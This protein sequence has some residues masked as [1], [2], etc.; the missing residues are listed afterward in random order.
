MEIVTQTELVSINATMIIQVLS[1]LIFLFIIQRI[2]FRPLRDTMESRSADLKRLQKEIKAQES[3][4]AELSSK[5]Q[6][7]AA[8]VKAEAFLESEKLETAGKQ[9]AGG[10]LDQAREQIEAQ[11]RKASEDIRRRIATVQQELMKETETLAAA[12]V[13]NVLERRPQP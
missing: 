6:K 4:L 12:I 3:R 2:M 5:M 13:A 1:F 8:A 9:E 7:E 10:I 11:Q